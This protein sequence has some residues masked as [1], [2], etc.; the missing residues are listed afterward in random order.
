MT[1]RVMMAEREEKITVS[2]DAA[3]LLEGRWQ[4]QREAKENEE[5]KSEARMR[6]G[7][8]EDGGVMCR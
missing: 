3:A 2:K 7:E 8:D 5:M 4:K 1:M 6:T